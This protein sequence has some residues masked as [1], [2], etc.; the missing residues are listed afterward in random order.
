MPSVFRGLYLIGLINWKLQIRDLSRKSNQSDCQMNAT[1][2]QLKTEVA[3]NGTSKYLNFAFCF[4]E[5]F[6]IGI[7]NWKPQTLDLSLESNQLIV[8]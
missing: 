2:Y 4:A 5:V 6:L 7:I 8:S 1:K 3:F